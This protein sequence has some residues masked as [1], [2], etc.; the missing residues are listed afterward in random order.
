ML[1]MNKRFLFQYLFFAVTCLLA[2]VSMSSAS[3]SESLEEAVVRAYKANPTLQT[4]R[5]N[6]ESVLYAVPE[7]KS[8]Y[9]P[10]LNVYGTQEWSESE[11]E[12]NSNIP[13]LQ[14]ETDLTTKTAQVEIIQALFRGGRTVAAVNAAKALVKAESQSLAE[15][16]QSVL[17]NAVSAYYGLE[18][19]L[20]IQNL[21]EKNVDVLGEQLEAT[22][23][24]FDVGELTKTDVSQAQS[25]LSGAKSDLIEAQ[26]NVKKALALYE[27]IIGEAGDS[28]LNKKDEEKTRFSSSLLQRIELPEDV[29]QAIDIASER[30]PLILESLFLKQAADYDVDNV[31]GELLPELNAYGRFT[32][33][34]D[35][36]INVKE[37]E[38]TAFGLN[39]TIPLYQGGATRARLQ[40]NKKTLLSLEATLMDTKRSVRQLVIDAWHEYLSTKAQIDAINDQIEAAE[41]ALEG[42]R[43]ESRVGSRTVL[44][45]LDAEEELLNAQVS[46]VSARSSHIISQFSLLRAVGLLNA[47]YLDLP[48]QKY[49]FQAMYDDIEGR[50]LFMEQ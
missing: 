37:S 10:S 21:R 30:N 1:V 50:W 44:D 45:V 17:L 48:T 16:E 47:N 4:A 40:S 27:Q 49:D 18:E 2:T 42:V 26:G 11:S 41:I 9:R 43:E 20:A 39:L 24:R 36:S 19:A 32:K 46:N 6:Y 22:Q 34:Y 12:L 23:A 13:G 33:S 5:Y 3:F 7:A 38:D 14:E 28:V 31:F 15:S 29:G 8:G 35:P 25:R